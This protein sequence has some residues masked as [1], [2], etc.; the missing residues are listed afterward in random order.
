MGAELVATIKFC[1]TYRLD[2]YID[3][4]EIPTDNDES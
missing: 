1:E 4:I 3:F 2:T